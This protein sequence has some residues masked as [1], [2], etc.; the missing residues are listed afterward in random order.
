MDRLKGKAGLITAAGSGMGRAGAEMFAAE[1]AR[2]AVCDHD[3]P[4]V[5]AVVAAIRDA[6]GEALPL[7][8]DLRDPVAARRVANQAAEAFGRLD[9]AWNHL[10]HPGPGAAEGIDPDLLEL[11][12]DLNLRSVIATTEAAIPHLRAAG[13]GAFLFTAST[14]G[15]VGSRHS[16]VYSAMKHGVV[17]FARALALK[18][19]GDGIRSN[20]VC[21][22]PIE[23]PM[24]VRFANR[25][26]LPQRAEDEVRA[27][28]AAGT[29][30][31]RVGRPEEVAAAALF[32]ISDEASYITGAA[33]PVDGGFTAG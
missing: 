29:P 8:A 22:G 21:P 4:A 16:P 2:V 19:A 11:A 33:L 7:V 32:L 5:E 17:G 1:G 28:A 14:G 23:T 12:I 18:L 30:M 3:G 10:G 9:F 31:R 20:V 27:T 26:D 25:P 6:G 15:L 24:M 13:N